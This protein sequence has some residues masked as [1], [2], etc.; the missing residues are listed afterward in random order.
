MGIRIVRADP[1]DVEHGLG[2]IIDM[3]A[4]AVLGVDGDR[5]VGAGGLAWGGGRAWIWFKMITSKPDYAVPIVRATKTMLKR[6]VQLG[7]SE[8][9]TPRDAA[10]PASKKLLE[11]LGF[12]LFAIE[13]GIEV[14]KWTA[15]HG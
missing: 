1:R 11:I 5:V 9:Y 14:W 13:Q 4:V 3:P 7:E 15:P 2:A 10:E 6:A 8:V 12:E